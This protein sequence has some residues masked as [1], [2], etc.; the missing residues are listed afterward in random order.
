[1]NEAFGA[2]P[3]ARPHERGSAR[4]KFIIVFAVVVVVG[5]MGVKMVPVWYQSSSFKKTLDE[6]AEMAAASGKSGDWLKTQIKA[7][8]ND[9][10]APPCTFSISEPKKG[11]DGRWEIAVG[12]K[13]PVN[14]LPFWT[15][16]YDFEYTA[17]S[18]TS[19][20]QQ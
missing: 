15:Y 14:V 6:S 8:V 20:N 9:Y 5:Y 12:I 4:I 3:E 2:S 19:A 1:M 11:T 16:N 18:R 10:C 7:N 17:R 13:R